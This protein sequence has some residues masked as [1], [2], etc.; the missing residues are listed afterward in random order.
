ML[1][2]VEIIRLMEWAVQIYSP[3]ESIRNA[4]KPDV[5]AMPWLI[6]TPKPVIKT[7]QYLEP[8]YIFIPGINLRRLARPKTREVSV[9]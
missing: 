5:P 6:D 8:G 1:R 2:L 3:N 4:N 7:V 9:M